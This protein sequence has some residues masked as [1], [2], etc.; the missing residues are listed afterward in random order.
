MRFFRSITVLTTLIFT[1]LSAGH[2]SAEP[3]TLRVKPSVKPLN[4]TKAPSSRDLMAAG[5][6]GGALYPTREVKTTGKTARI[7]LSF[8]RAIQEWN[9]HE[10]RKAVQLFKKHVKDFPDSPWASESVLHI[11]CDARYN[12]RYSEA[13]ESFRWIIEKNK[14]SDHIGARMLKNKA[15][16]R[17]AVLK[18]IENNFDEAMALFR[19]LKKDSPDWR[20]RTYASHWIQR[21][22]RYKAKKLAMLNCGTQ[23]LAYLLKGDGR[24]I[25]AR[26][27]M[28]MAPSSLNGHSL[29]DL[30]QIASKYDYPLTGLQ[31]S[32]TELS[33]IP[34]PAIVQING[35]DGGDKGHYWILEGRT[36][37]GFIFFDPQIPRRF[38]QMPGEFERE[39]NGTALVFADRKYLTGDRLP[40]I[41]MEEISGGCCGVPMPESY[42]GDPGEDGLPGVNNS[43][44]PCGSPTWSVNMLNMNLF[45]TD[46][47]LWYS[48]PIGPSVKLR[49]SYNS[50]SAIAN[51]EPF[52]NKWLF[53]YGSY[54]VVDTG[55]TVTIFM[56]DGRR[57]AYMPDGLGGYVSPY[58]VFNKLTKIS[59]NH[60]E[61]R[62]P[63]DTVYVYNIPSGTTSLQPFLVEIRDAYGQSL[64]FAYNV[65]VQLITITDALGRT[66]TLTYN[67]D[68]LVTRVADPFGRTAD[69]EYDADR[70]LTRITDM[71][72]YWATLSYDEDVYL[73]GVEND[74]GK[75]KFNVEPSD[76]IVANS[77][78]YPPPGDDMWQ[79]YRITVT[80]PLGENEEYFYYGG[81]DEY[82]CDGYAWYVS[83]RD[84]ITW[85]SQAVNNFRSNAPKTRYFFMSTSSGQKD[86]IWEILSPEGR[87]VTYSYDSDGNRTSIIDSHGHTTLYTYNGMGRVT[88]K[89]DAKGAVTNMT[90]APNEVDLL[91]IQ[92]S[93]GTVTMGYN[94][95][96][97][98]TSMTDRHGNTT[99]ISYNS[100]GQKTSKTDALGSVTNYSYDAN[101]RLQQVT[102]GGQV[103]ESF[104]YDSLGRVKSH[105]DA[106]SLILTYDY[107]N[108]NNITKKTYPDGKYA[109]Y[110]YSDC[111]PYLMDSETDR[112]GRTSS[113]THDALKRLTRTVNPAGG[114]TRYEYDAN[115]N[116]IELID[117]N[118][119]R[120]SF[121]YD[122]DN[123]LVR[124]TY[125]DGKFL[126]FGYDDEG[127][128]VLR[129][130]A[131]GVST[132]YVYD[133][134][135]NLLS[136][137]YSDGTHSV[138]NQYDVENRLTQRQDGA[139]TYHF[140]Y[141][142]NSRMTTMDGPWTDDTLTY[143]YDGLDRRISL[144]AQN[145]QT[146]S[147]TYDT[148][149]RLTN[150]QVGASN[151]PYT[152][153][154]ANP[155]I[156]SLARPN[157]SGTTYQ[158]DVLNRL[159]EISNKTSSSVVINQYAY[160][161][162][163][164]DMRSGE[165]IT[166]GTP[167]TS[168]QN[169][170]KTY[171]YNK[172][173]QLL[174]STNPVHNFIHDDSGNMTR[175]YTPEGYPFTGT[176][177]GE[178]RLRSIEYMDGGGI[179]HRNENT[180]SGDDFLAQEKKYENG[181][182]VKDTRFVRDG[183]LPIQERDGSNSVVR[184]YAWG[185]GLGGG[186]G[187][188]LGLKQDGQDYAYLYDG[189]GNVTTL[190]DGSQSV[191]AGYRYD[192][193]GNLMS[194]TGTVDQPYRF[195]TKVFDE[196]TGLS[197]YGYRFYAPSL[198]RWLTRD[199]IGELGGINLYGFMDNNPVNYTDPFGLRN[200]E[201]QNDDTN[202]IEV[203]IGTALDTVAQIPIISTTQTV[204]AVGELV[205]KVNERN[206][207]QYESYG[208][209]TGEWGEEN[210]YFEWRCK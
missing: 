79:N 35:R 31:L 154:G 162:N 180:Y 203:E 210:P 182:L 195:S 192:T 129:I 120:T 197:Y 179:V 148:L 92:D 77:D 102:I 24:E 153:T 59:E 91:Q 123:R 57:D 115:G 60:F 98:I 97:D 101:H 137:S 23:A 106:T 95:T 78:N 104:T 199:P 58:Q 170:L 20:H 142:A 140:T 9:R 10:Y 144:S 87:D 82:T 126:S 70:N 171:D 22:S 7:N 110:S 159:T 48:C 66:A 100:Y 149:G 116:R 50:Q 114:S 13:E 5:Q 68:G 178:N 121:E 194:K 193:F 85:A 175:G 4:L 80:N 188:L 103:L 189:K 56:P 63:D 36:D 152:Y 49:L 65:N 46:T 202:L 136:A 196:T 157:G 90:Y 21:L 200:E 18:V 84:Y 14:K 184:E 204:A 6:L 163:G 44:N 173:N 146:L 207:H 45:V 16:S 112:S 134:T 47:P 127:L 124:K 94:S 119:N 41:E 17:L 117:P 172:V 55:G 28:E 88:S 206:R 11:G 191:V 147:Y 73:T 89:T 161:Y 29:Q 130:D 208:E 62:L 133:Q 183:F 42:L 201:N 8:G 86:E 164:Q 93:L 15:K 111:C 75:W 25:E 150:I 160:V 33:R 19:D 122:L 118:G 138:T 198:G 177:D 40:A 165:T 43:S 53:N 26:E 38:Q 205:P 132:T 72:G 61:L 107:N 168:F 181:S 76:G 81:C 12:G 169:D 3:I 141:D 27:V 139:G 54:L 209:V 131:R 39:W 143:S 155:L 51:N 174:S 145:G 176:Y 52:G 125:A 158:Y 190:V 37:D 185:L 2:L 69:F 151:Y 32:V 113:Y 83:P 135:H 156:Q 30:K 71:G 167:M 74:R 108:L 1:L 105:M 99:T 96:H 187:G 166:N 128:L 186:I 67:E 64:T 109:T 34:L